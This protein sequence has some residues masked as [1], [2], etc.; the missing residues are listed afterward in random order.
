MLENL[1]SSPIIIRVNKSRRMRWAGHEARM[2]RRYIGG[3]AIRKETTRKIK[4]LVVDNAKMD[5]SDLVQ[6][7]DKWRALVNTVMNIRVP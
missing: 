4:T 2:G 7:A 1:Y 6:D 3:K 5:W